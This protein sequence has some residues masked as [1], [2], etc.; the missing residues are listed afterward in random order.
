MPTKHRPYRIAVVA[1]L[2]LIVTGCGARDPARVVSVRDLVEARWA[3]P[4]VLLGTVTVRAMVSAKNIEGVYVRDI[5]CLDFCSNVLALNFPDA[6]IHD[7]T[8]TPSEKELVLERALTRAVENNADFACMV[9]KVKPRAHRSQTSN[10][11]GSRYRIGAL[12]FVEVVDANSCPRS[13][14]DGPLRL[15]Q[16]PQFSYS[17]RAPR[18]P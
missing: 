18:R 17:D 14:E 4:P 15:D 9:L 5:G 7:N 3:T 16:K 6:D 1:C 10:P 12:D 8:H 11:L 13:P 2:G